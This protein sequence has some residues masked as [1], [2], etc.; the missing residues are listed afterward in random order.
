MIGMRDTQSRR[1]KIETIIASPYQRRRPEGLADI[2]YPVMYTDDEQSW[3]RSQL[4]SGVCYHVNNA[5][6]IT[7]KYPSTR[8]I[9][10]TWPHSA[11]TDRLSVVPGTHHISSKNGKW[12]GRRHL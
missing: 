3:F 8:A 1:A 10:I 5:C 7:V 6:T 11:L 4:P 9:T 2:A 12:Y